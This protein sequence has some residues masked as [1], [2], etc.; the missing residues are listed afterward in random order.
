[1]SKSLRRVTLALQT[2]GLDITPQEIGDATTA[3]MAADLVGCTIAQIAKSIMFR[4]E[5]SGAALLFVTSGANRVCDTRA[6]VLVGE[7]LGNRRRGPFGP[8]HPAVRFL[9]SASSDLSNGLGRRWHA[10]AP[11]RH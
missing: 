8:S 10:E 1:M 11:L 4:G 7:P 3:Q 2:A 6:S 5:T 9:R